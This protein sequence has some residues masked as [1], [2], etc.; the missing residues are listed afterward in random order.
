MENFCLF[1][2]AHQVRH[3]KKEDLPFSCESCD[4]RAA[5]KIELFRHTYKHTNKQMYICEICGSTFSRDTCLR[6]H[7]E[8]VHVKANKLKCAQV[9]KQYKSFLFFYFLFCLL[10]FGGVVWIIETECLS[11]F[12]FWCIYFFKINYIKYSGLDKLQWIHGGLTETQLLLVLYYWCMESCWINLR[13]WCF[14]EKL[15]PELLSLL[16][17]WIMSESEKDIIVY[18]Y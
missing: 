1:S 9:S 2:E 12:W 18:W 6:E 14:Y 13:N 11:Y 4:F 8:Y 10:F 16:L 15:N 3:R 7:I 17:S 5:S